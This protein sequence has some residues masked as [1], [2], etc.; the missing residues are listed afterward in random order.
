[1]EL[2]GAS[3]S[4]VQGDAAG[5][6]SLLFDNGQSLKVYDTTHQYESYSI[7]YGGKVIIV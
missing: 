2:L 3:V 5:T 6:L 4:E 1:M 7:A